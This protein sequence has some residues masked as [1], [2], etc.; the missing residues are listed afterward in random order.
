MTL[1]E[2]DQIS[3]C[4]LSRIILMISS[5]GITMKHER[6]RLQ[7]CQLG[8]LHAGFLVRRQWIWVAPWQ[9][10]NDMSGFLACLLLSSFQPIPHT[11]G[12]NNSVWFSNLQTC[13]CTVD[14]IMHAHT[15]S[16]GQA[17][18]LFINTHGFPVYADM[19]GFYTWLRVSG[20][21]SNHP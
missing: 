18:E 19:N 17:N 11:P 6:Q 3:A 16:L 5:K 4:T 14:T 9:R 20:A 1:N 15:Y 13:L 8:V 12:F 21:S 7:I 10:I 2:F